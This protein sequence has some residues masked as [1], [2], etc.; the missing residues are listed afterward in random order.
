MTILTPSPARVP[1]NTAD[2]VNQWIASETLARLTACAAGGRAAVERRLQELDRE[3]D[4]ERVIGTV[5]PAGIL[6]G[7]TLGLARSRRFF[8]MP[9]AIAGFLILHGLQGWAPPLPL[10]RRLGFR[11]AEEIDEERY[12]LRALRGDFEALPRDPER[13]LAVVKH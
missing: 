5:A 11:T 13:L 8:G 6:V 4:I 7:L 1:R 9:A 2:H 12:A 3:W 10:L